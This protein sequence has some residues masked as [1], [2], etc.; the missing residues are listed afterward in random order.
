RAGDGNGCKGAND[1]MRRAADAL[2]AV[3]ANRDEFRTAWNGY[4][5][6]IIRLEAECDRYREAIEAAIASE[7]RTLQLLTGRTP[8]RADSSQTWRILSRALNDKEAEK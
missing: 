2:E 8:S 1:V 5:F 3:S 7:G 4:G 6:E